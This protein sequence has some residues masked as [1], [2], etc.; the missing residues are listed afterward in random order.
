M[1]SKPINGQGLLGAGGLAI[2][3]TPWLFP[4]SP[5]RTGDGCPQLSGQALESS[6]CSWAGLSQAAA[7]LTLV[8]MRLAEPLSLLPNRRGNGPLTFWRL[9]IGTGQRNNWD[10]SSCSVPIPGSAAL[11]PEAYPQLRVL[12]PWPLFMQTAKAGEIFVCV[13]ALGISLF[14]HTLWSPGPGL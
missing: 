2:S 1:T 9:F 6:M 4:N 8:E 11:P 5:V 12:N 13:N 14:G 7:D 10:I 3:L